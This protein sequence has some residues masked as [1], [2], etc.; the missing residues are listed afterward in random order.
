MSQ[1]FQGAEAFITDRVFQ[2]ACIIGGNIGIYTKPY[3][4][5]AQDLMPFLHYLSKLKPFVS[6]MK[7]SFVIHIEK[8]SF[9][10][11]F[12]GNRN[13]GAGNGQ[14]C[15]QLMATHISFSG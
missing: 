13:C 15:S 1:R 5:V 2:P 3:Q 4:E 12:D 11:R 8:A 14:T 10:E 9:T 6:Q 7:R